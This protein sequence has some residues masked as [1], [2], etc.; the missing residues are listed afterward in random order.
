MVFKPAYLEV[1]P[2]AINPKAIQEGLDFAGVCPWVERLKGD[3]RYSGRCCED[4]LP[5]RRFSP[6]ELEITLSKE[7]EAGG[8]V[9]TP[10]AWIK[11]WKKITDGRVMASAGDFY[12]NFKIIRQ[13]YARGSGDKKAIAEKYVLGLHKDFASIGL[14]C[15]TW[16]F[17]R[18]NSLDALIVQHYKCNQPKLIKETKIIVPVYDELEIAE[19][20]ADPIGKRFLQTLF[21]TDDEPEQIIQTLGFIS[22]KKRSKII[23][24][25]AN[26]DKVINRTT[27]PERVVWLGNYS[28]TGSFGVGGVDFP[29]SSLVAGYSRGVRVK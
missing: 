28:D 25:T 15:N 3:P 13:M 29:T 8:A 14:Y 12:R 26:N 21:D 19:I 2:H 11:Y 17:Y 10:S 23:G 22:G 18:F 5:A 6:L 1:N 20:A 7:A 9:G 27:H 24:Q 16:L 4:S